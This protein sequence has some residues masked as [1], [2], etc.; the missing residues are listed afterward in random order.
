MSKRKLDVGGDLNDSSFDVASTMDLHS[1]RALFYP[2]AQ[3]R[4]MIDTH[5]VNTAGFSIKDLHLGWKSRGEF[6]CC[7]LNDRSGYTSWLEQLHFREEMGMYAYSCFISY[8][9]SILGRTH[10]KCITPFE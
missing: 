6:A 2:Q 3:Q 10:V 1:E 5:K 4:K 7:L 9:N 8:T